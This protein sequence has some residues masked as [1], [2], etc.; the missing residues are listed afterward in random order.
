MK[1]LFFLTLLFTGFS[2][3]RAQ[4]YM[5]KITE[6]TCTCLETVSD[7]LP[8]DRMEMQLG[9]CMIEAA[10]PYKKQIKKDYGIDLDNIDTEGEKLGRIIGLQLA[11][12]CP[13]T[14]IKLTERVKEKNSSK[15]VEKNV[16]GS[17]TAID[18]AYFVSFSVRDEQ[19]KVAKY[20]WLTFVDSPLDM[21]GSY[22]RLMGKQVS[23]TYEPME[24][25]DPKLKEYRSFNVIKKMAKAD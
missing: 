16:K 5:D 22:D 24:F 13:A 12:K 18:D 20:I 11:G 7:T 1:R 6:K 2:V 23:I 25:F 9:L 15:E 21:A 8:Q 10:M 17:V 14:L 19:G 3:S 4:T